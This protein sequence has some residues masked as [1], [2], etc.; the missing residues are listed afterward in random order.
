LYTQVL[1]SLDE[2]LAPLLERIARDPQLRDNT[3][4]V[5]ASDNGPEPGAGSAGLLR[6]SKGQLWEGGVRSPLIVWGPGLVKPEVAGSIN[7]TTVISS[8]D[9]M[10]SLSV[11]GDAQPPADYVPDGENL[12][13]AMLGISS[14]N[15]SKPLFWRRPPDRPGTSENPLPDLAVRDGD[16]KLICAIDGDRAQLFNL[17]EDEAEQHDVAA[18]HGPVVKRLKKAVLDWN[19][20]LPRDAIEAAPR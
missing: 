7:R 6:G 16:W 3:L 9:V 15:R 5:L 17:A 18:R 10:V 20:T 4:I 19:A 13:A 2:Q 1:E 14:A 12:L 8:I 11:L